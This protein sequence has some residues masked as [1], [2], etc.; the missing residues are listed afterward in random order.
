MQEYPQSTLP[1]FPERKKIEVIESEGKQQVVLRG[2]PY[3]KWLP[4]DETAPRMAIVQ[5]HELGLATQEELSDAFE[6][7]IKSVY[8]YINAYEADGVRGL[9]DQPRGPKQKW[10]LVPRLKAEILRTVLLEGITTYQAVQERL[11]IKGQKISVE[12]IRQVLIETG[13]A[14][15]TIE[16]GESGQGNLFEYFGERDDSQLEL[17]LILGEGTRKQ[18]NERGEIEKKKKNNPKLLESPEIAL[19]KKNRSIYSRAE[20]MYLD[21]LERGQYSTYAGG[22]LYLPLLQ[23]YNFLPIIKEVIKISKM[24]ILKL[25]TRRS[26]VY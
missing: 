6:V 22:L 23:R 18:T 3:M 1:G 21:L 19:E 12:S 14:K 15:E 24:R 11:E 10:K 25:P 13:F 7:H 26:L 17:P 20:R 16:I 4:E 8:N 5:L 9:T 2:R